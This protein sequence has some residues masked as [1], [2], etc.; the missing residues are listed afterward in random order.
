MT[1]TLETCGKI[2]ALGLPLEGATTQVNH[3]GGGMG[4]TKGDVRTQCP[5][6]GLRRWAEAYKKAT[7]LPEFCSGQY[8]GG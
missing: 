3:E 1:G 2:T 8:G 5:S 4:V 6:S 7:W